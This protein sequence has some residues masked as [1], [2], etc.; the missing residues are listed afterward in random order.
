MYS[1]RF[2]EENDFFLQKII[3]RKQK[4]LATKD[5]GE[6]ELKVFLMRKKYE[7]EKNTLFKILNF[8]KIAIFVYC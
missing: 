6:L 8:K 5:S 7:R 3:T 4:I 2:Y 1:P